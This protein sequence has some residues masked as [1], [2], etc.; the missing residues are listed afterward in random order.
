MSKIRRISTII[1]NKSKKREL[2]KDIKDFLDL[3]S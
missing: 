2:L 1:F 3:L